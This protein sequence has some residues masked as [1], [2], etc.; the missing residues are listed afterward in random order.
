MQ[1]HR[2]VGVTF[3]CFPER[4]LSSPNIATSSPPLSESA[5]YDPAQGTK[6][7]RLVFPLPHR[8]FLW[9]FYLVSFFAVL[10]RIVLLFFRLV[11]KYTLQGIL[12]RQKK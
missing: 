2:H 4:S 12:L 8:D 1:A 6:D 9:G 11:V 3:Y 7:I 5:L 10:L